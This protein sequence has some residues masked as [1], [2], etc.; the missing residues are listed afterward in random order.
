[1]WRNNSLSI[2]LTVMFAVTLVAHSYSGLHHFN[3]STTMPRTARNSL[4]Q[5]WKDSYQ[6]VDVLMYSMVV[7]FTCVPCCSCS[8]L[9]FLAPAQA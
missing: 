4:C 6:N 3:E 9:N 2:V 1:M 7:S 8:S 5:F